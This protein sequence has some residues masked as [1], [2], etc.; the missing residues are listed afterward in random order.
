MK[1]KRIRQI[2]IIIILLCFFI[3]GCSIK[4]YHNNQQEE[5]K[6]EMN[7]LIESYATYNNIE[8]EG[9][10]GNYFQSV[11]LSDNGWVKHITAT[12]AAQLDSGIVF[13]GYPTCPWCRNA[14]PIVLDT[15][16][17]SKQPLLY[18]R[19][20]LYRD[21]YKV[22]EDNQLELVTPAG[23]GYNE[24]LEALDSY[25][26]EYT[27]VGKNGEVLSTGEKRVYAPTV[28]VY[29]NGMIT[30]F[31]DLSIAGL[32]LNDGQTK[33]DSWTDEQIEL[34]KSSLVTYSPGLKSGASC[35]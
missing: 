23:E 20:D 9:E 4:I 33:Y 12:E 11:N 24:L 35:P 25:L 30:G 15:V 18:C 6:Q 2:I 29:E 1:S 8:R 10:P 26:D 16:N 32:E 31:W 28:V 27:F 19:L 34:V 14:L 3:V 22:T 13:F 5:H 7:T 17:A 21:E